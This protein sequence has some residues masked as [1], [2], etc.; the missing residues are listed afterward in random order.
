MTIVFIVDS[1][2]L[3]S[4]TFIL[5]QITGLKDLGHEVLIFAGER[6]EERDSHE[7]VT[8]YELLKET[9]YLNDRPANKLKR[10]VWALFLMF[11]FIHRN[12][13]AVL[14][15]LNFVKYGKEALS[16]NYFYKVMLFLGIGKIDVLFCHYGPNGNLGA[17][18]KEMGIKAKL[19]TMFHGYD[20]RRGIEQ[21]GVIYNILFKHADQ[22]LSISDYNYRNLIEFGAP[23]ERIVSHPVG[24]NL[25]RY[26]FVQRKA[27]PSEAVKILS[28]GRLVK[29]KG[30]IFGLE[31]FALLVKNN[32]ALNVQYYIV[33]DGPL[34]AELNIHAEKLGIKDKV[35][36]LGY[37]T[38]KGVIQLL[39]QSHMF[40][41]PSIAE[42]LPV[43][44]MEAQA[45]GMPTVA[46]NVGSV[47]QIVLDE[48][49]GFVV[50]SQNVGAM[51]AK[52]GV[53]VS[54]PSMWE[55]MGTAGCAH[56]KENFDIRRLNQRLADLCTE[57]A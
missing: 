13:K 1:F 34:R 38:Q 57:I 5:N 19:I 55:A 14:N 53:L 56:V 7:D 9:Y 33:G 39:H 37:Q 44:L 46:A 50:E 43:V 18:M 16:L 52:L 10:I 51:S 22:I 54:N 6:S 2:P 23:A 17:L 4:E 12:P 28:V 30:F 47:A 20:I 41:L 42:A 8:K 26:T 21:G 36:F 31:A 35:F 48:R 45:T 24:I 49:T 40:F 3:I 29:E 27:L 32:P 25:E 15:S 11:A